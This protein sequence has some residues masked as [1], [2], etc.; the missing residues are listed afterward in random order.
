MCRKKIFY[1]KYPESIPGLVLLPRHAPLFQQTDCLPHLYPLLVDAAY[2]RLLLNSPYS[3]RLP[4]P[5]TFVNPKA[6]TKQ[7]QIFSPLL[8]S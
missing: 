1:W 3:D 7:N 8:V 5:A 6:K 4:S 2:L